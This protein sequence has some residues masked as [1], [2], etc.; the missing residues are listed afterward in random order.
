MK[1]HFL[2]SLEGN[3]EIYKKVFDTLNGLGYKCVTSHVLERNIRDVRKE[4]SEQ[5][6]YYVKKMI[7]W[8][9][10]ADFIVAEVTIPSISIG[11]EIMAAIQKGKPVVVIY[12]KDQGVKPDTLKGVHIDKLQVY[13]YSLKNKTDLKDILK[14]ACEEAKDQMDTRFNFFI[15]PLHQT[16]LDWIAKHRKIP[17]SV[18]LRDLIERDMA[19]NEEFDRD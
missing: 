14:M 3:K 2:A 12:N 7:H 4:T 9:K 1:F 18:Y 10:K 11:Y 6:E 8:V 15:S 16:Y 19:V 13:G 5:A 17:R